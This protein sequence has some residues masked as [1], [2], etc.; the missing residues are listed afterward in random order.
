MFRTSQFALKY[1]QFMVKACL[2][3]E[4]W[5]LSRT[6]SSSR[7]AGKSIQQDRKCNQQDIDIHNR[8]VSRWAEPSIGYRV[9]VGQ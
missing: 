2:E 1:G 7:Q 8:T 5:Y 4:S 9:G 3:V 6:A